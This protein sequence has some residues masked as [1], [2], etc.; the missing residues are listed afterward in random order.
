MAVKADVSGVKSTAK[1]LKLQLVLVEERVRYSGENGVRFHP[2]VVRSL[3]GKGDV[4]GFALTAGRNLKVEHLF[5]I[6]KVTSEAR[7]HLDDFEKTST[8]FPN[9]KFLEKKHDVDAVKLSVVAFVQD[10]D[11][12]AI[13]QA[14][15][16]TPA[17]AGGGY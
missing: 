17:R 9:H 10:E 5:D 1:H 15:L 2:M 14:V 4:Q 7:D 3:A 13:L 11:S 12:K 8:R 16:A 6:D